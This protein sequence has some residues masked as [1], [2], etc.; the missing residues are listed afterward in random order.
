MGSSDSCCSNSLSSQSKPCYHQNFTDLPECVHSDKYTYKIYLK[1]VPLFQGSTNCL[2]NVGRGIIDVLT[3]GLAEIAY[4]AYKGI[5]GAG[6]GFYHYFIEMDFKCRKCQELKKGII[7]T[8]TIE[9]NSTRKLF[10]PGY[11][12][13]SKE[14]GR[15][16]GYWSYEEIDNKFNSTNGKYDP[17]NWNC[18]HFAKAL[19]KKL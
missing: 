10:R 14:R 7:K 8:Y 5:T 19:F 9:L 3:L 2:I 6:D 15:K 16:E 11:Y 18:G 17:T 12:R 4:G 1:R 13:N